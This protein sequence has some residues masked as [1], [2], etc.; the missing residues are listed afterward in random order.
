MRLMAG[1]NRSEV[2]L[3]L[4]FFPFFPSSFVSP[5]FA[6]SGFSSSFLSCLA[7]CRKKKT[8]TGQLMAGRKEAIYAHR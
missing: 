4:V 1:K 2:V 8:K 3:C 6:F 7:V 5:S